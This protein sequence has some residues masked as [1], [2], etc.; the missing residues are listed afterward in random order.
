MHIPKV[1]LCAT[2]PII[3][4]VIGN[5]CVI[6]GVW[7]ATQISDIFL[8]YVILLFAGLNVVPLLMGWWPV[9]QLANISFH[10]I[11]PANIKL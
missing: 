2:N 10:K 6:A 5:V 8:Q 1:N 11:E 3:K 7:E 4:R 9:H